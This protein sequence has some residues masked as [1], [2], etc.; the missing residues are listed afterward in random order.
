M[1]VLPASTV[2]GDGCVCHCR[3]DC[4]S[5]SDDPEK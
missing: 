3:V 2:C 1:A 4:D 5:V